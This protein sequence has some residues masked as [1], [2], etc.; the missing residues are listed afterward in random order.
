MISQIRCACE[1]GP[2]NKFINMG[3]TARACSFGRYCRNLFPDFDEIL[4]LT[5][6]ETI[7]IS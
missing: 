1:Q 4:Y 2:S 3:A 5:S 6:W 7:Y